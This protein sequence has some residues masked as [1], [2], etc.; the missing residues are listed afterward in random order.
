MKFD[1]MTPVKIGVIMRLKSSSC[2][3]L[4][5]R[6]H[7]SA[8]AI[9]HDRQVTWPSAVAAGT[10]DHGRQETAL[11]RGSGA[12]PRRSYDRRALVAARDVVADVHAH[13]LWNEWKSTPG[14]SGPC[15][16][17]SCRWGRK[18]GACTDR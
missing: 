2:R 14:S 13:L 12:V 10:T 18:D 4:V 7:L 9:L 6:L 11:L 16:D 5:I 1:I 17:G 15:L 8:E 3:R